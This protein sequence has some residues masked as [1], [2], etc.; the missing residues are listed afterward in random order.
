M[1]C[2]SMN[3]QCL[4][5]QNVG[6]YFGFSTSLKA[7]LGGRKC[8]KCLS[9]YYG[10]PN[11]YPC[12]CNQ[13]GTTNE[14]CNSQTAECLCKKNVIG[15][16]CDTCKR[17]TFDL[18]QSHPDGCSDCHCF[19]VTDKC[20]SSY[21]PV[22]K[23]SFDDQA[24]KS[25]DSNANVRG[26]SGKVYYE[27][28]TNNIPSYNVYL[29]API[30]MK[31]DYTSSYGL[32]ITFT[33]SCTTND[34]KRVS[35]SAADV[36]LV[37]GDTVLD[38]WATQQPSNPAQAFKVNVTLLPDYWLSE[39]GEPITRSQLMM[40]LLKLER[41]RIKGK[42]NLKLKIKSLLSIKLKQGFTIKN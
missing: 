31:N 4:C 19:G 5:K 14:V 1:E 28:D 34:E 21:F 32:H 26:E 9:G 23:F 25:N 7:I 27:A 20:Q 40:V 35:T 36:K 3:G 42:R 10:F 16:N 38:F 13:N 8:E 29:D 33:I 6:K 39:R 11:C 2:D 30:S 12:N 22:R 24:W 17:G 37:S 15:E 41:L 18:R